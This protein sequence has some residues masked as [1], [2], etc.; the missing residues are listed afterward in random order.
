MTARVACNRAVLTRQHPSHSIPINTQH[1]KLE[2]SPL[3]SHAARQTRVADGAR[4]GLY[5]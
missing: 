3:L 5:Q 2:I 1:I 4:G